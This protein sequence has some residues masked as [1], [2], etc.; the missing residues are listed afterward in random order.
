MLPGLWGK[1]HRVPQTPRRRVWVKPGG[2]QGHCLSDAPERPAIWGM[3]GRPR[4]G[5]GMP[6]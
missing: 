2:S 3:T 4:S 6:V 5:G 1:Q